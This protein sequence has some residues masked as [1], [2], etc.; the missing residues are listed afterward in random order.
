MRIGTRKHHH[1]ETAR[2]KSFVKLPRRQSLL[3]IMEH[4]NG[5]ITR[6]TEWSLSKIGQ[7]NHCIK[8]F[9]NGF[10]FDY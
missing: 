4:E 10:I 7:N 2:G 3:K 8:P 1:F 6:I 9:Q 5:N